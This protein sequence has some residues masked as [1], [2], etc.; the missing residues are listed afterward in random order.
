[1]HC[2]YNV[3]ESARAPLFWDY[4]NFDYGV[5]V[6]TTFCMDKYTSICTEKNENENSVIRISHSF[7]TN[8]GRRSYVLHTLTPIKSELMYDINFNT[9]SS[10]NG[11]KEI[12]CIIIQRLPLQSSSA[13]LL[14]GTM[15]FVT[16]IFASY[17]IIHNNK[18]HNITTTTVYSTP[19]SL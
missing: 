1:M 11:K 9:S 10:G 13:T 2:L 12:F 7:I 17:T 19:I 3:H 6:C 18:L 16:W 4:T 14:R 8:I 5:C 15:R